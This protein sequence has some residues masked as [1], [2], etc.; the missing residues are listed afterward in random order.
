HLGILAPH[1]VLQEAVL[2]PTSDKYQ[3]K[4]ILTGQNSQNFAEFFTAKSDFSITQSP[5]QE[6]STSSVPSWIKNNAGWWSEGIVGDQEFVQSIQFLIKEEILSVTVTESVTTESQ[7]I[8]IWVK[9]NAGWWSEGL[10]SE[11]DFVKGVE[12]LISQGI[13]R[14]N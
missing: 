4:L 10:I 3:L 2:I 5:P 14:V 1:G 6:E 8:P 9:N 12:F 13:I 7:D 11:R